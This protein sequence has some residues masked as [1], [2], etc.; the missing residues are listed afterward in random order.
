MQGARFSTC[1]LLLISLPAFACICHVSISPSEW[2]EI[3]HG[4]PTFVGVA[5]SVES[6]QD[7]LRQGGGTPLLDES[8]KPTPVTVQ[9]VTFRVDE[10][11][12]G[13]KTQMAEVYGSG[14]TC[15]Y[16]FTPGSRYLVYGWLDLDGKIR[17]AKCTR[18]VPFNEAQRDLKF[19]RSVKKQRTV[20]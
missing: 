12:E 18:T 20:P 17:T 7:V 16:Q 15:D 8:G 14:T 6:V 2:Y 13:I 5:V 4:Q 19:L 11:F 1:L 3:H 9:K 10:S